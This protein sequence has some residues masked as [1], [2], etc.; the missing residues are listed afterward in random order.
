MS[1]CF[2]IQARA[3]A[4][5]ASGCPSQTRTS[6]RVLRPNVG[7]PRRSELL[8]KCLGVGECR[9]PGQSEPFDLLDVVLDH[10][11]ASVEVRKVPV[12]DDRPFREVLK[13]SGSEGIL[14]PGRETLCLAPTLECARAD[15]HRGVEPDE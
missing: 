3:C 7:Q 12:E 15:H 6:I 8:D 9:E 4:S 11:I 10:L 2:A 13:Q 5:A 1:G 14:M